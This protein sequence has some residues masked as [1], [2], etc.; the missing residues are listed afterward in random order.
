[1]RETRET[2]S[3]REKTHR[4]V[5]VQA[6]TGCGKLTGGAEVE[7][8]GEKGSPAR[9]T[10]GLYSQPGGHT[11]A[12]R[13]RAGRQGPIRIRYMSKRRITRE[14]GIGEATYAK[15]PPIH[16]RRIGLQ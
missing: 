12:D 15:K 5:I 10:S 1:M 7:T 2:Q 13:D 16:F 4:R 6:T 14:E 3:L 8:G 11:G 9:L